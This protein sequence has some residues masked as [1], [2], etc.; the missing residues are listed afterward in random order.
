MSKAKTSSNHARAPQ[1]SRFVDDMRAVFGDVTVLYV[2]E[3]GLKLGRPSDEG[4]ELASATAFDVERK[5]L[6]GRKKA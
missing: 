1:S 2:E 4:V 3:N 6:L 5:T